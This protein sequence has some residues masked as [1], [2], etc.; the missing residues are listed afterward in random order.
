MLMMESRYWVFAMKFF[1]SFLYVS[2][3]LQCWEEKCI[4]KPGRIRQQGMGDC[5]KFGGMGFM[6]LLYLV[7]I[8][9]GDYRLGDARSPTPIFM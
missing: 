7:I 3:L 6:G 9:T 1:E 2:D 4:W 8:A 5:R